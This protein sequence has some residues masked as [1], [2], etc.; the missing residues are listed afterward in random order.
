MEE[1]WIDW[2]GPYQLEY[3]PDRE[4]ALDWGIYAINRR[5]GNAE[6]LLYVGQAYRQNMLSRV[7]CHRNQW[8]YQYR[9][10]M[11]VRF[12]TIVL[13]RGYRHSQQRTNDIEALLIYYH[14]PIHNTQH[15]RNYNGRELLIWNQ[16][17]RGLINECVCTDDL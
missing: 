3:V 11:L 8:I 1:L 15:K 17:R 6:T 9:G 7:W 12:G 10:Q 16:G 13:D 2:R 5:W 14:Q 4:P